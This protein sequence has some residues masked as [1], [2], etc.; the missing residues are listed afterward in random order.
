MPRSSPG[1]K[2]QRPPTPAERKRQR[3][4]AL[5]KNRG[6]NDPETLAVRRELALDRV[7]RRIAEAV[8]EAPP[9]PSELAARLQAL[10][11][12]VSA[13]HSLGDAA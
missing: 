9:L 10:I 13:E 6:A 3:L 8:A 11:R 7:E 12:T 5:T 4:A 1:P 2:S